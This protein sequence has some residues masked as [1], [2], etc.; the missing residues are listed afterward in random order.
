MPGSP[1]VMGLQETL[2]VKF[3]VTT[4][5]LEIIGDFCGKTGFSCS[6]VRLLYHN[7]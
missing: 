2:L 1:D 3:Q 5:T 7:L 4:K 6:P